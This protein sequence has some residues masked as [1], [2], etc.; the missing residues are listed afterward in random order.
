MPILLVYSGFGVVKDV[1]NI[2]IPAFPIQFTF[3]RSEMY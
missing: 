1:N 3:V 2:K